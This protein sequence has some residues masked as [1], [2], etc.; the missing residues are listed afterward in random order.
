MA[1]EIR[2]LEELYAFHSGP[3][4][5]YLLHLSGDKH[6]AEDLTSDTFYRAMMA[7][8]GFRNES[9]VRTWLL[10][11]ARNLYLSRL[12][13]DNRVQS[14]EQLQDSGVVFSSTQ[15]DPETK[16]I[17]RDE[18]VLLRRALQSLPEG[19]RTILL[20]SIQQEMSCREI[21]DMFEISTT[22]VKVRLFRARRHLADIL[23]RWERGQSSK[24]N[25]RQTEEDDG[26]L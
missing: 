22:A 25:D 18:R 24:H 12:K 8:D 17:E 11:I 7:I 9:S 13:R 14:L 19:E 16:M 1:G 5:S 26:K 23:S 20:L 2:S 3:V 10:R 21:S 6:V 4:Y 15:T